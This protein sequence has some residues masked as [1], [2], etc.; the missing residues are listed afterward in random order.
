MGFGYQIYIFPRWIRKIIVAWI[1]PSSYG[2]YS[3]VQGLV[4]YKPDIL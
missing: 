2:R 3:R 4:S 1:Q